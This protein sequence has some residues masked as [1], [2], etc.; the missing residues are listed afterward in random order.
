MHSCLIIQKLYEEIRR[1]GERLVEAKEANKAAEVLRAAGK[2]AYL[3]SAHSGDGIPPL[4]EFIV[5][6]GLK[7]MM[8]QRR[9]DNPCACM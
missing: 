5:E 1:D 3:C 9:K 8:K 4:L 7:R 6:T 2:K